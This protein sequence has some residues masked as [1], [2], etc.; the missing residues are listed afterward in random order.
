MALPLVEAYAVQHLA[1]QAHRGVRAAE[2]VGDVVVHVALVGG[3]PVHLRAVGGEQLVVAAEGQLRHQLAGGVLAADGGDGIGQR[4]PAG[5]GCL[6]LPAGAH[7]DRRLHRA[8]IA[9]QVRPG[10]EGA[11]AVAHDAQRHIRIALLQPLVQHVDV[12]HHRVPGVA[13]TEIH[14]RSALR[15]RLAVAQVVVSGHDDALFVQRPGESVVPGDV[16]GHAVTDLQY[17]ADGHALRLPQHPVELGLAVA[18]QK[19]EFTQICH[20]VSAPFMV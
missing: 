19:R 18:G 13:L 9:D 6:G 8:G 11:H 7:D 17:S 1:E 2:G 16:L 14:R 4:Q 15:Q 3:E 10:Q 20:G 5:D 12:V